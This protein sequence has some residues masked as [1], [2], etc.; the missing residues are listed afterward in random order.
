[1][2]L[3]ASIRE[4][5]RSSGVSAMTEAGLS[6]VIRPAAPEFRVLG[7][8][9]VP[10]TLV[11]VA[12][13]VVQVIAGRESRGSH[14]RPAPRVAVARN[15][16][17][18]ISIATKPPSAADLQIGGLAR[19][20]LDLLCHLVVGAGSSSGVDHAA[21][22]VAAGA[23]CPMM[24]AGRMVSRRARCRWRSAAGDLQMK[25]VAVTL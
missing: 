21:C 4:R 11:T 6:G 12:C 15:I 18:W 20:P 1:M 19:A 13:R 8:W 23:A 7:S 5:G 22:R 17:I 9:A 3:S 10:Q 16:R 24:P 2:I 14:G 25:G